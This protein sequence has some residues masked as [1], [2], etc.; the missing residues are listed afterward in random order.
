MRPAMKK[1]IQTKAFR[2]SRETIHRLVDTPQ[3]ETIGT[4]T[5]IPRTF[6]VLVGCLL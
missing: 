1:K 2:L 4:D 6:S 3:F 5:Q